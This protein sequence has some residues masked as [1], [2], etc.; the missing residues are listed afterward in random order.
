M[1]HLTH[2]RT[3]LE[4]YRVRSISQAAVNLGI[5]QPTASL[6][7]QAIEMFVG[8]PLFIRQPR[9]VASTGAA[10]ELARSVAPHLD[11]L[12]M[13]HLILYRGELYTVPIYESQHDCDIV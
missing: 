13:K 11:S 5:T 1:S 2:L 4:V 12:E 3:F 10:D 6:H 7:I 8:K 9:G